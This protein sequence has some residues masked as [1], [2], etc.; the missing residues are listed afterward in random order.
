[1]AKMQAGLELF[2]VG[3]IVPIRGQYALVDEGGK[4]QEYTI[5]L[6][7]GDSFPRQS[8]GM[9]YYVLDQDITG[10]SADNTIAKGS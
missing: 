5:F 6:E 4:K 9:L 8:E 3:D 7:E 2:Q 1:M 10:T